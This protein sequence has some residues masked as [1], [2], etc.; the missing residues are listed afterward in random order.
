MQGW[1]VRLALALT[2][3][4]ML[5]AVSVP[6]MA[7][8]FGDECFILGADGNYVEIDCE[9]IIF[10]DGDCFIED[11]NG[12]FVEIDCDDI[13]IATSFEDVADVDEDEGRWGDVPD[14]PW[15]E[16]P[17][18]ERGRAGDVS[19]FGGFGS[20]DFVGDRFGSNDFVGDRF[21]SNDDD[22]D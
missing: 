13:W 4:A 15:A 12:D 18:D 22:E 1:K 14:G 6:S 19:D 10:F 21:G 2:M 9:D 8:D 20:N 11:E 5:I 3:L 17:W 16:E 7:Q